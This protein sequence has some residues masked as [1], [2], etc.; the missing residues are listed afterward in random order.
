MEEQF[1]RI[2]VGT[3]VDITNQRFGRWTVLY[4]TTNPKTGGARWVCKCD[5]G[6]I[7][8]VLGSRLRQ[9]ASQSC[10]CFNREQAS[11]R[12]T[13]YN[14]Q[15]S[16]IKIGDRFDKLVV[17]E[18]LGLRPSKFRNKQDRWY[19]CRCDCGNFIE[20]ISSPLLCGRLHSCGCMHSYGE[21]R[22]LNILQS[23]GIKYQKEF[24]FK[25]LVGKTG[26]C[27]RFDFAL[28]QENI[29]I[30]LIEFDGRQHV[31]GPE[32]SWTQSDSLEEIQER[33]KQKDEYCKLHN[34]PLLRLTQKDFSDLENIIQ[35]FFKRG[36]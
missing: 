30:G 14:L 3:A 34:I 13:E 1:E 35:N 25:D 5:C 4:R 20:T 27:L 7:K 33:D 23:F 12:M 16:S 15:Q 31:T 22:I 21:Y 8:P 17:E 9:G 11:K 36:K 26:R 2:E 24:S 10:G 32:A 6:T 19:L 28:F 29:L 18:D